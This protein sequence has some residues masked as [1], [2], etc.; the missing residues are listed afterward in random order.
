MTQ[1]ARVIAFYLPQY[2]PIPENDKWWG[3]GF[4]EWTNV[5]RAKPLFSGHYQPHIPADLGFYDLRL[6]EVREAQAL[7]AKEH[8]VEGFCYYHYWMGGGRRLLERPFNE[9]L[10]TKE[11]DFPF[12][13]CWANHSWTGVWFGAPNHILA[14]QTY[15]GKDDHE[16]HFRFLLQ[17]FSDDRYIKVDGKPLFLIFKPDSIPEINRMVDLWRDLAVKAGLKG[18]YLV[19]V[20]HYNPSWDPRQRGLDACTMQALPKHDG[21]IPWRFLNT[22]IK[23]A[24]QKG[25]HDLTIWEYKDFLPY[26]L[27]RNKVDWPDYPLVLPNWDNTPRSGVRGIVLHNSTPELFRLHLRAAIS[28]AKQQPQEHRILFLKAWNEWAEGNYVEPDQ[29]YG[30]AYLEVIRDEVILP[31]SQQEQ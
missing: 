21:H 14:E 8:G 27:R 12:C 1:S 31:N 19:G 15:P 25:K 26:L 20:S 10:K 4:T 9:V 18:L 2:H 28:R 23:L 3:K 22:K 11:P 24:L 7:L 13:L 5:A 30:N 16:A 17:A 6:P 29:K